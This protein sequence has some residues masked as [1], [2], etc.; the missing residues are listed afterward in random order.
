MGLTISRSEK[1]PLGGLEGRFC[2]DSEGAVRGLSISS[3]EPCNYASLTAGRWRYWV[4]RNEE[5]S[6]NDSFASSVERL[7]P[8]ECSAFLE[9]LNDQATG[10]IQP[11][12][13]KKRPSG[14]VILFDLPDRDVVE[15]FAL[16]CAFGESLSKSRRVHVMRAGHPETSAKIIQD[17][18][19][20]L[21]TNLSLWA[22]E[23]PQLGL[24]I[25]PNAFLLRR[26]SHQW[27]VPFGEIA[28]RLEAPKAAG[29]PTEIRL[30][31]SDQRV[32]L[33][34][35]D[36]DCA[37][38]AATALQRLIRFESRTGAL[39]GP[40]DS[41][42]MR[43]TR[44]SNTSCGRIV[45]KP[46]QD[47]PAGDPIVVKVSHDPD[48]QRPGPDPTEGLETPVGLRD[49]G[50]VF[51]DASGLLFAT[52]A[53]QA[54]RRPP[55][56]D[57]VRAATGA[58]MAYVA[59]TSDGFSAAEQRV[60]R[61][62]LQ[63]PGSFQLEKSYSA[64]R[65]DSPALARAFKALAGQPKG[66]RERVVRGCER[67]ARADGAVTVQEQVRLSEIKGALE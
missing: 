19:P 42:R 4:R 26:D 21:N 9:R 34:V 49:D 41:E 24:V 44:V 51:C 39:L 54:K 33:H 3:S 63:L 40:K 64:V 65:P 57:R 52:E 37:R 7:I 6:P 11:S 66:L 27:I 29:G 67:I 48:S 47:T 25:F 10:P 35:S 18:L 36:P 38:K 55:A 56:L 50:L 59:K 12:F 31:L 14:E 2:V 1:K 5:D 13:W 43:P 32:C 8:L 53:P 17:A 15:R 20:D 61:E 62:L 22:V 28:V 58:L 16:A 23:A 45:I 60:I 46:K 30:A